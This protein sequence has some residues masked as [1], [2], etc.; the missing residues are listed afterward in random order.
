MAPRNVGRDSRATRPLPPR[1]REPQRRL[2][3]RR[4]A[5]RDALRAGD[6]ALRARR[7]WRGP[8]RRAC[9]P[10][11]AQ[12]LRPHPPSR[13]RRRHKDLDPRS[14]ARRVVCIVA[15]RPVY[16]RSLM[17]RILL[18]RSFRGSSRLWFRQSVPL[19][20]AEIEGGWAVADAAL[21]GKWMRGSPFRGALLALILEL[22]EPTHTWKLATLLER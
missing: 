11:P 14:T 1:S 2:V 17:T 13:R 21:D 8:T 7:R 18:V 16:R 5:H 15:G 20:W 6:L 19:E 3:D 10:N 12:R 22:D 9:L 4:A